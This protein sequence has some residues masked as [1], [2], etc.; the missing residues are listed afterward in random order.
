VATI[1]IAFS[2]GLGLEGEEEDERA[3]VDDHCPFTYTAGGGQ[4]SVLE[5]EGIRSR[6]GPALDCFDRKVQ[7]LLARK[8]DGRL[9]LTFTDGSRIDVE[10][11]DEYEA[12]EIAGPGSLKLVCRPGGGE[13]AIWL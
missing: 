8:P 3:W 7:K 10:P 13:P 11:L 6:L 1:T 9:D 12:W 2:F 4:S 5:P